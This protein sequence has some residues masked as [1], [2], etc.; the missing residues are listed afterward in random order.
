MSVA[1]KNAMQQK[2]FRSILI[3]WPVI[4]LMLEDN[5]VSLIPLHFRRRFRLLRRLLLALCP[6]VEFQSR[7]GLKEVAAACATG[8]CP[9]Q[10]FLVANPVRLDQYLKQRRPWNY[11]EAAAFAICDADAAG[12]ARKRGS[13]SKKSRQ[14][15]RWSQG[16]SKFQSTISA[17][18]LLL[19]TGTTHA[20]LATMSHYYRSA[21]GI[22]VGNILDGM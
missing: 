2:I 4:T 6:T 17:H 11:S 15:I 3:R 19:V 16:S 13:S 20:S 18:I 8:L 10:R 7:A 1:K 21:A 9:F 12:V 22:H 5:T 14:Y